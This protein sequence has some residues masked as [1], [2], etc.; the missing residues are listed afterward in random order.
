M[1][2]GKTALPRLATASPPTPAKLGQLQVSAVPLILQPGNVLVVDATFELAPVWM[3]LV[4]ND[5]LVVANN[6]QLVVMS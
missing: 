4:R 3:Y 2:L 5:T 6:A 1:K